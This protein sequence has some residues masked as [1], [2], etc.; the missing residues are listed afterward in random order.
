M[1]AFLVDY[2]KSGKA[3]L[4]VGSGPSID[5]GYPTS[6]RL[7]EAALEIA[8]PTVPQSIFSAMTEQLRRGDYPRVFEIVVEVLGFPTVL[9]QLRRS[10]Q[11]IRSARIYQLLAKW[12]IP[13]YLTT[14]YDD[15]IQTQLAALG[16]AYVPYSNSNDH[17]DLLAPDLSGAIFKIHG[18]LRSE[19]G[20]ILTTSQYRAIQEDEKWK[21]WRTKLT[22]VFQLNPVIIV[23]HSL[24]DPNIRHVLEAAQYGAGVNQPVCWIAPDVPLDQAR[25]YLEKYRIRVISY[26]NRD[27]SHCN[28][29]RLIENVTRFVYP[30]TAVKI[31]KEIEPLITSPL[32]NDSAAPGFFVFT[33]LLKVTDFDQARVTAVCAAIQSVVPKLKE[34]KNFTVDQAVHLAG[35]PSTI[36]L[37]LP[38][39]EQVTTYACEIG[40]LTHTEDRLVLGPKAAELSQEADAHFTHLKGRFHQSLVLRIRRNYQ[41]FN[42]AQAR[43]LATDIE[44]SL[45]GFFREAGLSLATTLFTAVQGFPASA[46]PS[47]VI[48]YLNQA[49]ARYDDLL[50]RQAFSTIAVDIF[51]EPEEADKEYLGRV[52][53]GFFSFHALGLFGEA[54]RERLNNAKQTVWL[55]DSSVQIPALAIAAPTSAMFRDVFTRLKAMGIRVFSTENIF[56]ETREHYWFADKVIQENGVTSPLILAAA[57]GQAPFRKANLFLEGF[58]RWQAA[59]NPADWDAYN[60]VAFGHTKPSKDNLREALFGIGIEVV[61]LENWPGYQNGDLQIS[62]DL[63]N[64]ILEKWGTILSSGH[65]GNSDMAVDLYEKAQPEAEVMLVVEEERA[66]R[67]HIISEPGHSS[68][69]WFI[70]QTSMLN[71]VHDGPRITWQPEAFL[72]F[73]STLAPSTDVDSAARAFD[74]L[75]FAFTEAGVSLLDQKAIAAVFGGVID[76]ATISLEP[77]QKAYEETLAWKYG[78]DPQ[79]ILRRMPQQYRPLAA[80]QIANEIALVQSDR[81]KYSEAITA[82]AIQR[83]SQAEKRAER[84][85]GIERKITE[86]R[87]E[88]ERQARQRNA[89]KPA[90]KQK[91]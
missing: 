14:N 57:L 12:P 18:D 75:L 55:I 25:E 53:Q 2:L 20:L 84:L 91:K 80:L 71:L 34:L 17:M 70:S 82:A 23:G 88:R 36:D 7:A 27:G 6:K 9:A 60:V 83:A 10:L 86:K 30:R 63:T 26:D 54:A 16:E 24:T 19:T 32:G 69:A 52:S 78:E 76:Q 35:W 31:R 13:V 65:P 33:K 49:A 73:A 77:L 85:E 59:G 11:P 3:W 45:I 42:E 56:D 72:R 61:P 40:L 5:M 1:D 21:Y 81:S 51:S 4:L 39:K 41:Q 50:H 87:R 43:Q 68:P 37:A 79:A 22:S 58:V 44:A 8:R 46:V 89:R 28:L 38:F 62:A 48:A 64:S 66:G 29:Y 47:S 15:E 90:K 67:Y 74:V